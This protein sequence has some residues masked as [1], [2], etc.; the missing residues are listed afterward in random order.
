MCEWWRESRLDAS[1]RLITHDQV[2]QQRPPNVVDCLIV[3]V[4]RQPRSAMEGSHN[5][6]D[7]ARMVVGLFR[8]LECYTHM[9]Q[10]PHRAHQEQR[11]TCGTSGAAHEVRTSGAARQAQCVVECVCVCIYA[12]YACVHLHTHLLNQVSATLSLL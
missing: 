5:C 6:K 10:L 2:C 8:H 9:S 1:N 7:A 4:E 3:K 12:C 11:V